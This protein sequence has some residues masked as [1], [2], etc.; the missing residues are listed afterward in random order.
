MKKLFKFFPLF[1]IYVVLVLLFSKNELVNDE[2]RYYMFAQNLVNGFYTEADNPNLISGP[3]YPFYLYPF[4]K[5]SLPYL[6]PRLG[7]AVLLFFSVI[8]IYRTMLFYSS[9][10]MATLLAYGFGLQYPMLEWL[11]INFSECLSVLSICGFIYYAAKSL[12]SER[13]A[14][15]DLVLAGFLLGYLA[16]IKVIFGYAILMA[17]F[18]SGIYY[19]NYRNALGIRSIWILTVA[20]AVTLPYLIYTHQMTG[21]YFYWGSNGGEQLYWMTTHYPKEYGSW[22]ESTS[23]L[24][25]RIPDMHPEH[26]RFYDSVYT[27]PWVEMN[28][29]F[30]KKAIQNIKKEPSAYL[31]NMVAN[32]FRFISDGPYSYQHQSLRTYFYLF[33]NMLVIIPFLFSLYPA[34]VHR[35]DLPIEII[36]LFSFITLYLGASLLLCTVAR[37][38]VMV[39]PFLFPWFAFVYSHFIQI[40]FCNKLKEL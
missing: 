34:W 33:L 38:F 21:R 24:W 18:L 19:F 22:V 5:W 36:T 30:M 10:R 32:I 35:H 23:V 14:A 29:L 39:V 13:P 20:F 17:L 37:Y 27:K 2:V 16:L 26:T 15:R 11:W 8:F 40:S 3:G 6:F 9:E 1:G 7:N 12:R 4:V 31:Y 28:D 25:R